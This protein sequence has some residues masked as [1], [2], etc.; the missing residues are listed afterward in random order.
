[1]NMDALSVLF[2]LGLL[3]AQQGGTDP[4]PLPNDFDVAKFRNCHT[5]KTEGKCVLTAACI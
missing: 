4:V 5:E 2:F 3:S 1:M